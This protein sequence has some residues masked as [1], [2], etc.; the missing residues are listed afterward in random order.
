MQKYIPFLKVLI[1]LFTTPGYSF[2]SPDRVQELELLKA[3]M[4]TFMERKTSAFE[5][6]SAGVL[7]TTVFPPTTS[8]CN[9]LWQWIT[10]TAS[11]KEMTPAQWM[12][13]TSPTEESN[14]ALGTVPQYFRR[15]VKA[16]WSIQRRGWVI[17]GLEKFKETCGLILEKQLGN[18]PGFFSEHCFTFEQ[19][20]SHPSVIESLSTEHE[21][22]L[23]GNPG[24]NCSLLGC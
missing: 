7:P 9:L 5:I 16:T 12:A 11:S 20:L 17:S 4:H 24:W 21:Y 8:A 2:A 23:S 22:Q 1:Q 19:D 10:F 6:S 13:A 15:V 14:M 18:F 3:K